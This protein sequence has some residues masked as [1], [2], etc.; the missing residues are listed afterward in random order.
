MQ[1]KGVSL[2][3]DWETI[4]R[5]KKEAE[6]LNLSLSRHIENIL[7]TYIKAIEEK[8][9]EEAPKEPKEMPN[10]GNNIYA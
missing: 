1:R 7:K 2:T 9:R 4:N 6:K 5:L 10:G 8:K 3:I